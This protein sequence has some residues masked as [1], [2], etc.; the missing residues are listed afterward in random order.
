M[1]YPALNKRTFN[2]PTPLERDQSQNGFLYSFPQDLTNG[3]KRNFYTQI[4]FAEYSPTFQFN[5]WGSYAKPSGGLR[6]P[7]PLKV[8]E[9]FVLDW[10]KIPYKDTIV[11]LAGKIPIIGGYAAGAAKLIEGVG[12]NPFSG[13]AVNPLLFLQFQK[14]EFK[15]YSLSWVM[16]PRNAQESEIIKNVVLECKRAAAPTRLA[17]GALLG[18]PKTALIKMWPDDL[19]GSIVFKPCVITSVQVNYTA[20]PNPSFFASGAPTV[21]TLTLNLTEMQFWYRDEI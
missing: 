21:V 9:S 1:P 5:S 3:D 6:L 17:L 2:F 13:V 18:Y 7:I 20:A 8:N 10:S 15:E 11:N 19:F 14:P 16:T 4:E 12:A